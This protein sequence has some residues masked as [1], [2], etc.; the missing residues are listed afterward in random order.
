MPSLMTVIITSYW[1]DGRPLALSDALAYGTIFLV[2][3]RHL[4]NT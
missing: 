1:G 2:I 4:T 3:S